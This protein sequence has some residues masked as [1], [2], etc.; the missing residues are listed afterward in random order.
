MDL[1]NESS[2]FGIYEEIPETSESVVDYEDY[3]MNIGEMSYCHKPADLVDGQYEMN[4]ALETTFCQRE[5]KREVHASTYRRGPPFKCA[6]CEKCFVTRNL[7]DTHEMIH[8][9]IAEDAKLLVLEEE[10]RGLPSLLVNE[11]KKIAE[12]EDSLQAY[13]CPIPRCG[14]ISLDSSQV[15][16]HLKYNHNYPSVFTDNER[17]YVN[18]DEH[19]SN[20]NDSTTSD[21]PQLMNE[22]TL[23]LEESFIYYQTQ[24]GSET[25]LEESVDEVVMASASS[26]SEL[27]SVPL[28]QEHV[29]DIKKDT[30]MSSTNL[31]LFVDPRP[32]ARGRSG[33]KLLA[34]SKC[35]EIIMDQRYF[36][37]V[38][39]KLPSKIKDSIKPA[40]NL[41]WVIEAVARGLD[42]DSANP[43]CRRKPTTWLCEECD[44][45][46]KYP[47]RIAA[48]RRMHTGEKPYKCE[49][50]EMRFSQ[51]TPMRLHVRRHLDQKPFVCMIDGCGKRYVSRSILNNHQKDKHLGQMSS[52]YCMKGCGSTFAS[53]QARFR[54]EFLCSFEALPEQAAS[55]VDG[56]NDESESTQQT[57][58]DG[59]EE[60]VF[61]DF[62]NYDEA[63]EYDQRH[64]V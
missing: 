11:T 48:H 27:P 13:I 23:E 59:D 52:F 16:A 50:C 53:S 62:P 14:Y 8:K 37:M 43:H 20:N 47:S 18:Q 3:E 22:E 33:E 30:P 2:A 12:A 25:P 42:I 54:H 17:T 7:C 32:P 60:E 9:E 39:P 44:Q 19:F 36:E 15:E 61:V 28:E 34:V 40:R 38:S 6:Y 51:C 49:I 56:E 24:I 57:F 21:D 29:S 4:T 31:R 1:S 58:H 35:K 46:I 5:Q 55:M 64:F 63:M 26:S 10:H 45:I 41:N